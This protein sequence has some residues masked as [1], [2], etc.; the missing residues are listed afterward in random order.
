M[1]LDLTR[2]EELRFLAQELKALMTDPEPEHIMLSEATEKLGVSYVTLYRRLK[3]LKI[4]TYHRNGGKAFDR[5]HL[6]RLK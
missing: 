6:N 4:K 2:K 1:V 5:K 3:A